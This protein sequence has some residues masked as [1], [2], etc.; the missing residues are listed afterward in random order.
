MK[1]RGE[2]SF[3]SNFFVSAFQ[4]KTYVFSTAEH[5][6]QASKAIY[7]EEFHLI[8]LAKS[9]SEAKKMGKRI[10]IR[11]DWSSVKLKVMKQVLDEKFSN[12]ELARKL[13]AVNIPIIEENE[14][15][16]TFWGVCNGKG[17]NHLGK[18]LSRIR[19]EKMIFN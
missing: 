10:E 11:K 17:E 15:G 18:I 1:F 7:E 3:L 8:R 16:D 4:Y 14:W 5:A 12:P 9:P 2:Y 13:I 19:Q 6:Y